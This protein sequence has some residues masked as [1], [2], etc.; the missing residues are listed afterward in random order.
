[1]FVRP[2]ISWQLRLL[3]KN[4]GPE[5]DWWALGVLFFEMLFRR[6]PFHAADPARMKEKIR[7][8]QVYVP[9]VEGDSNVAS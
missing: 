4:Y 2:G 5:V 6:T 8:G 3:P 7:N 9:E 1:M